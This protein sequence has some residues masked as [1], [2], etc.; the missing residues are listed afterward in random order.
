MKLDP[1]NA[2]TSAQRV[3]DFLV[4]LGQKHGD[5][6]TNLKLQK[7]LYYAQGWFI[8]LRKRVL[9]RDPIQAWP[10]G[11]V[12]YSVWKTYRKF[13][14]NPITA[15]V[16]EPIFDPAEVKAHLHEVYRAFASVS[17]YD[18][19]LMTHRE[20][21][22]QL[23]RQGLKQDEPSNNEIS[24]DALSEYFSALVHERAR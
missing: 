9:F 6:V 16:H 21:P 11:P 13:R 14:W 8:G 23:A 19:E 4:A 15:R 12:V 18:L 17:A 1:R 2:A 20:P 24:L 5:P 7:L 3:A 22:W 10:R